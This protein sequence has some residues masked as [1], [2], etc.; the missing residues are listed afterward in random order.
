MWKFPNVQ[1]CKKFNG[2]MN[3]QTI[4]YTKIY[5]KAKKKYNLNKEINETI[6]ANVTQRSYYIDGWR[7]RW[8]DGWI[9]GGMDG[10]IAQ[11]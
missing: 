6:T 10:W 11:V 7:N 2:N 9:D 4:H 1:T 8:V 3:L 5:L